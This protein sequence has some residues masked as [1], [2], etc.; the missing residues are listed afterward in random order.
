MREYVCERG[1][2]RETICERERKRNEGENG[3]KENEKKRG[4]QQDQMSLYDIVI[5]YFEKRPMS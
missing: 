5:C 1:R 3:K 4:H 2:E